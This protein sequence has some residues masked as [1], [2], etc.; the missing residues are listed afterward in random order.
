[1]DIIPKCRSHAQTTTKT[2]AAATAAAAAETVMKSNA[3]QQ[4]ERLNG[5][6]E[7]YEIVINERLEDKR[8]ISRSIYLYNVPQLT[9]FNLCHKIYFLRAVRC[10][11]FSFV[12]AFLSRSR[13]LS[14]F[15]F[16]LLHS[17]ILF[18]CSVCARTQKSFVKYNEFEV[19]PIFEF[20]R[21]GAVNSTHC[22]ARK[23]QCIGTYKR[24]RKKGISN[25]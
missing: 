16:T 9:S 19:S 24:E 8:L 21:K 1:M 4:R 5:K 14:C 11:W 17:F 25:K 15:I 10:L 2:T 22:T 20:R 18:S 13:S 12:C 7:E 6:L 3:S 23:T